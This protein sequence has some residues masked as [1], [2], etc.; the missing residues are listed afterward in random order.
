[1]QVGLFTDIDS[2]TIPAGTPMLH[3]DGYSAK[4]V[5]AAFYI[6]TTNTGA[7]A[8][9][10]QSADGQWWELS[11]PYPTVD[12]LG[13]SV[14]TALS[15][16][17]VVRGADGETLSFSSLALTSGERIRSSSLATTLTGGAA[18]AI[19]AN[20]VDVIV[21]D[22]SFTGNP[23]N[24]FNVNNP[25][26]KGVR[27]IDNRLTTTG[28]GV[29]DN[30]G[31]DGSDVAIYAFNEIVATADAIAW[32]HP[33]VTVSRRL[34]IGNVLETSLASTGTTAGFGLSVAATKD[35]LI[36][37]NVVREARLEAFHVED[38]QQR[39][40]II[41][42]IGDNLKA[43]GIHILAPAIAGTADGVVT[44]GNHLFHN[45]TQIGFCGVKAVD[46]AHGSLPLNIFDD[47]SVKGFDVGL[48]L[49]AS[50]QAYGIG[51]VNGCNTALTIDKNGAGFGALYTANTP[52]L[53]QGAGATQAGT[54][55]S[56]TQPINLVTK[57][58]TTFPGPWAER[59]RFPFPY[60][61]TGGS[62][63]QSFPICT[64]PSIFVGRITIA[65]A[66]SPTDSIFY[67]AEAV[68]DGT[69]LTLSSG[70]SKYQGGM[71]SASLVVVAGVLNFR[72]AS[73]SA[74]SG[75]AIVDFGCPSVW[76]RHT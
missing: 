10:T 45:G 29:L 20:A 49:G 58:D 38:A 21:S 17:S 7:T 55:F 25:N 75:N 30:A 46:D 36:G 62:T 44:V 15:Y 65:T 69:T 63:L 76:Y 43:D 26:A 68:W 32:N 74:R 37:L 1:M 72:F 59:F 3:T 56:T 47:F 27:F 42:N 18:I 73:V 50:M 19:A 52:T 51:V 33:G 11:E 35:W 67:S 6:S 22:N 39:G 4:G 16:G 71:A 66:S 34:A 54:F 64:L 24:Y 8:Y 53:F 14:T 70:V 61:N 13:G 2:L 48:S 31:G 5:G 41:G 40:L 12:M 23:N 28:Y 57:S 60:A 9:R